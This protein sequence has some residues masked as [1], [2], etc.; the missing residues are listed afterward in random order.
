MLHNDGRADISLKRAGEGTEP[1]LVSN[2]IPKRPTDEAFFSQAAYKFL[3]LQ[4]VGSIDSTNVFFSKL[5]LIARDS[6][7]SVKF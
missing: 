6:T 7:N 1:A 5:S 3:S 4:K 2:I